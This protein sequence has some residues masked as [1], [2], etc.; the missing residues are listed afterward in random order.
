MFGREKYSRERNK[1]YVFYV[2]GTEFII[3][4]VYT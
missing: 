1:M 3:L 4:V 2:P